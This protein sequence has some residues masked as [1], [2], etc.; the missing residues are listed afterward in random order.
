MIL[1]TVCYKKVFIFLFEIIHSYYMLRE[2]GPL[3]HRLATGPALHENFLEIAPLGVP[4]EFDFD[5]NAFGSAIETKPANILA[6]K[7]SV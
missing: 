5:M 1:L 2:S 3:F 7:G 4:V 6:T